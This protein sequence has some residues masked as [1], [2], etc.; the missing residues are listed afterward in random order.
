MD[1]IRRLNREFDIRPVRKILKLPCGHGSIEITRPQ[2]TYI[3]CPN[4]F[5]KFLLIYQRKPKIYWEEPE[6]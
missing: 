1:E 2:D 6:R 4:C 5:K 3:T